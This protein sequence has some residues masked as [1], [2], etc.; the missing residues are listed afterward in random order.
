L[1]V[2]ELSAQVSD[3]VLKLY[4]QLVQITHHLLVP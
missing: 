3:H 4:R 1:L 2:N